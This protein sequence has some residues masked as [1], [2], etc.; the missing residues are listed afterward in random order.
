M[1][2]RWASVWLQNAR[3][4]RQDNAT[5]LVT[6]SDEVTFS[7]LPSGREDPCLPS[8]CLSPANGRIDSTRIPLRA[9]EFEFHIS[10]TSNSARPQIVSLKLNFDA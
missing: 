10:P 3:P 7:L 4:S 1:L 6:L 5:K 8:R 2:G 9:I